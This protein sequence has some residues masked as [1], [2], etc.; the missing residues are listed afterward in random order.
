MASVGVTASFAAK[1]PPKL[2]INP[3]FT[4]N[5]AD[6]RAHLYAVRQERGIADPL[7]ELFGNRPVAEACLPGAYPGVTISSTSRRRPSSRASCRRRTRSPQLRRLQ[8]HDGQHAP[9]LEVLPAVLVAVH[10]EVQP[11][12]SSPYFVGSNGFSS[13]ACTTTRTSSLPPTCR[14]PGRT[15]SSRPEGQDL[16]RHRRDGSDVTRSCAGRTAS[17]T[18][19]R[20]QS[21]CTSWNTAGRGVADLVIAGTAPMGFEMSSSYYKTNHILQNAPLLLQVLNPMY[22]AYQASSISKYAPHPCA[23]MLYVDWLNDPKGGR[24]GLQHARQRFAH[25]GRRGS[26][27]DPAVRHPRTD[28]AVEVED[29]VP[30]LGRPDQGLQELLPGVRGVD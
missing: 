7:H 20:W 12:L 14:R 13:R 10:V 18:T 5:K 9:R 30:D 8:R 22:G 3:I 19:R 28:P 6:R 4:Y 2:K 16:H 15:C 27:D 26:G 25:E 24:R 21:R 11:A 29:H 17:G 1:A 23:A